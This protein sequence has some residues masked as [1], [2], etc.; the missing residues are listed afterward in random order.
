MVGL[1]T[2]DRLPPLFFEATRDLKDGG[3]SEVLRSEG[4]LPHR[5]G[6][7]EAAAGRRRHDRHPEPLPP[8]PAAPAGSL[9]EAQARQRLAEYKRR[10]QAGQ[11]DFAQLAR[12]NSQDASARNGGD[13]GWAS[14]GMFVPEFEEA[15][16]QPAARP[17]ADPAGHPLRRAPD[18]AAGAPPGRRGRARAARGGAQPGARTQARR[19]LRA[20]V[21]AKSAAA[22]T[23]SCANRRSWKHVARKRFGQHFLADVASS[24]RSCAR[25]R[26]ARAR[27]WWRSAPGWPR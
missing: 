19:G 21:A 2:G 7:G 9:S 23:S 10:I 18:P 13:L 4:R 27:P 3:V 25:S 11:A 20:V 24:T 5:Q 1:R 12:E 8:H 17:D 6:P 15:L 26:R 16:N 14:P 22:P